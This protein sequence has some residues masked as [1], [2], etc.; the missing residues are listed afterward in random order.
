MQNDG[1]YD[2]SDQYYKNDEPS[3][4]DFPLRE[5][6]LVDVGSD[7][8]SSNASEE[9]FRPKIRLQMQVLN[10]YFQDPE[11]QKSIEESKSR[12]LT[13]DPDGT[14]RNSKILFICDDGFIR[15]PEKARSVNGYVL[16]GGAYSRLGFSFRKILES[17]S[18][19]VDNFDRVEF[20][21]AAGDVFSRKALEFLKG[22]VDV[23]VNGHSVSEKEV[24][25]CEVQ[26]DWRKELEGTESGRIMLEISTLLPREFVAMNRLDDGD[27]ILCPLKPN[28]MRLFP[29]NQNIYFMS[30]MHG[31]FAVNTL[32][33]ID[34]NELSQPYCLKHIRDQ[35]LEEIRKYPISE[36]HNFSL[37]ARNTDYG[38]VGRIPNEYLGEDRRSLGY[39]DME[40]RDKTVDVII[41]KYLYSKSPNLYQ[42][43]R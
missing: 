5:R 38:G 10:K 18:Y 26:D 21:N 29:P 39:E 16:D 8:D 7:E 4:V 24:E 14:E 23:Q 28:E 3:Q 34:E 27:I 12:R 13:D 9:D 40:V 22:V 35:Y 30:M 2:Y 15:S 36:D 11:Y 20:L 25:T 19:W 41:L 17:T 43:L 32:Q 33:S 42:L 1:I 31:I 6:R 37:E